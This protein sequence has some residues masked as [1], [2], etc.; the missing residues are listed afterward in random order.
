MALQL[1]LMTISIV[2]GEGLDDALHIVAR[3]AA[4]G[5]CYMKSTHVE[6]V[7]KPR[8]MVLIPARRVMASLGQALRLVR[9][10]LPNLCLI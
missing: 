5:Q 10:V 8:E 3:I 4:T 7:D 2:V 1:T 6:S 9:I